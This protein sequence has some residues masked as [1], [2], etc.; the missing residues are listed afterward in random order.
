M[1][2]NVFYLFFSLPCFE[3]DILFF[4]TN[5][6]G[7]IIIRTISGFALIYTPFNGMGIFVDV[8]QTLSVLFRPC[9]LCTYIYIYIYVGLVAFVF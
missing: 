8:V 5:E 9:I 2:L 6:I 7:T 3:G 4:F 1:Y